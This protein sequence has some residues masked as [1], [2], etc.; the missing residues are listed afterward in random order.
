MRKN[1]FSYGGSIRNFQRHVPR[2]AAM[3]LK[4]LSIVAW[5]VVNRLDDRSIGSNEPLG[6]A[7]RVFLSHFAPL[8]F[9]C[10]V[11]QPPQQLQIHHR[12]NNGVVAIDAPGCDQPC[13]WIEQLFEPLRRVTRAL[14]QS[15]LMRQIVAKCRGVVI[16]KTGIVVLLKFL[17]K[18]FCLPQF[19]PSAILFFVGKPIHLPELTDPKTSSPE[20][21]VLLLPFASFVVAFGKEPKS[22]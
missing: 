12:I 17:S 9:T 8:A 21:S 16:Q 2:G 19:C 20:I 15:L 4:L 5:I 1:S 18:E 13:T 7:Q 14:P 3:Q 22:A 6:R 11:A 10:V